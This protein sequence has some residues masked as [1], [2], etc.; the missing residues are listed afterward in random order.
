MV[1][2]P[3]ELIETIVDDL[4]AM[5]GKYSLPACA[6]ASRAFL[7]PSQR[8]LFR[9]ISLK[10][11]PRAGKQRV[12]RSDN[13]LVGAVN[14]F[15]ASPRLA[16]YVRNLSINITNLVAIHASLTSLL[17]LLP[18]VEKFQLDAARIAWT[19]LPPTLAS[20]LSDF[21]RQPS[22]RCLALVSLRD[23]SSSL[24]LRWISSFRMLSLTN[25]TIL[26]DTGAPSI[27]YDDKPAAT[28]HLDHLI[29]G[30][31]NGPTVTQFVLHPSTIVHLQQLRRLSLQMHSDG[32]VRGFEKLLLHCAQSLR[33]L[34]LNLRKN[35]KVSVKLPHLPALRALTLTCQVPQPYI[36]DSLISAIEN[37]PH[38][39]PDLEALTL[40]L[41]PASGHN[42]DLPSRP[43]AAADDALT[44]SLPHLHEVNIVSSA[45]VRNMFSVLVSEV[46]TGLPR[47]WDADLLT[48]T[49]ALVALEVNNHP[50]PD[51]PS[52]GCGCTYGCA[53][54][55]LIM[56]IVV[57]D[58]RFAEHLV[59]AFLSTYIHTVYWV[60]C[61]VLACT[62]LIR[63]EVLSAVTVARARPDSL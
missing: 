38:W 58:D 42:R 9:S 28:A 24:V 35:H 10:K 33:E 63:A 62:R 61:A 30:W 47:V 43:W 36:P 18:N 8:C 2:L 50:E 59:N 15:T 39:M 6:L 12:G 53:L 27:I 13:V 14:I 25:V 23:L 29:L 56:W 44:Q 37:I 34:E 52:W 41:H 7:V 49:D 16:P 5:H 45:H 60:F 40:A 46:K 19:S 21:F 57:D 4:H 11:I 17:P 48:F 51:I 31:P 1:N 22:L 32:T 54:S 3:Q 55:L 20:S 26:S